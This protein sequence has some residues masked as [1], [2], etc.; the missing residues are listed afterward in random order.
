MVLKKGDRTVDRPDGGKLGDVEETVDV[1]AKSRKVGAGSVEVGGSLRGHKAEAA[2][3]PDVRVAQA[4]VVPEVIVAS[5]EGD[6]PG[7][8]CAVQGHQ[9]GHPGRVGARKKFLGHTATTVHS[10]LVGP[11]FMEGPG[12]LTTGEGNRAQLLL[13]LPSKGISNVKFKINGEKIESISDFL[14]IFYN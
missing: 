5:K 7:K 14:L 4:V 13:C 12:N 1:E 6:A 11:H 9:G 10:P 3:W 2:L 8:G